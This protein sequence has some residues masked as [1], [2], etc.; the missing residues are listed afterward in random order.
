MLVVSDVLL[1]EL[2]LERALAD[3]LA[4]ALKELM[5]DSHARHELGECSACDAYAW[6]RKV[7]EQWKS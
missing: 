6:W 2:E 1:K 3:D 7:S 4:I 5:G